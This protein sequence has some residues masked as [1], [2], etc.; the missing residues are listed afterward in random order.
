MKRFLALSL[1]F[2]FATLPL[3]ASAEKPIDKNPYL[4]L[5]NKDHK[6][7][8]DWLDHITLK[9]DINALG[10]VNYVEEVAL[11]HFYALQDDCALDGIDIELDSTYRSIEEQQE[12]WDEWSADPEKGPEYCE[13]YLAKVGYSE[14]HTGLAIDIF[15]IR[16][17]ST[18]EREND[19]MIADRE[20]FA[21]IHEKLARHG[22]ILRYP[23]GKEEITGYAYEPWHFRFVG[24]KPA[25][26]MFEQNLTL[27]EYLMT[28][29]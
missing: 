28:L 21:K 1:C 16:P 15:I 24:E 2:L 25:L 14:H 29:N 8:D 20:T 11:A 6:L 18:I 9:E 5:V 23:E 27:E 7:P 10:E 26:E 22:Y 3:L 13:L 19:D 4:I 17:D 12:I